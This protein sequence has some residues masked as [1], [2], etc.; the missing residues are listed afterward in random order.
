MDNMQHYT[1][2]SMGMAGHNHN[3]M[4][5]ADFKKRFYVV[6]GTVK[7]MSRYNKHDT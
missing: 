6:L 2:P 5:I 4:M 1:N 3:A 7:I